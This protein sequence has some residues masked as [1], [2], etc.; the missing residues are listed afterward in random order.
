MLTLALGIAANTAIFSAVDA[1]LLHPLPFPHAEQLVD[2][3]KT[4]PMF[5]L[6]QSPASALDFLDYR[7]QSRAFTQIAA[8]ERAQFNLTG[9]REAVRVPG[10]RVS[11]SLFP[12]LDVGP[13]LGRAFTPEEE[14]WGSHRVAILGEPLWRARFGT[15][16]QILG[17]QVQLDGE[18]YTVIG[19]ARP[20]LTFLS[21]N[22][23]WVPLAFSPDQLAPN[24]RGHQHL[25]VVARLRPG[26][27]LAQ[28]SV[29]LQRVT[30]QL[31]K[32]LP[33]WYPGG[34]SINAGP[35]AA[36]VSGPI[37]TPLLVLLGAVA[38]VLL[39]GCVNVSNLLLA[40]ASSRQKEITIRTALGAGRLRIVRQLLLESAA[41][42]TVSGALGL[43]TSIWALDLFERL[44]PAGLLRGQHLAINLAVAAFTL[45]ISL[46]AALF[47]GLAPA[48]TASNTDLNDSLKET[49]R[50]ASGGTA[51]RR[52]REVLVASEVALSLALLISAGLL[53]R[54]F[55]QLQAA[56][57]GFQP[58]HL[59]TLQVN[60]PV[61]DY[62]QPAQITAFYD[63]LLTR[64]RLI[65]GVIAAGAINSLP[66]SGSNHGGDFKIIG[67]TWPASQAIPDVSLRSASAEY[68]QA[69]QIPVLKGRAFTAENGANAPKVAVVDEAFAKQFFA[70]EDPIGRQL[71]GPSKDPYTIIG[72]V[73]GVKH[74]S[75][76]S[77]PE[78]TIY[79]P[80]LQAP[81]RT[82]YIVIRTATD[83]LNLLPVVRE[84]VAALD[85]NLPVS[86]VS[87]MEQLMSDSLARTRF[88]TALLAVFAGLALLL[89]AIGVYGVIAYNVT[90]RAQEIGIRIALGARPR[91]AVLLVLRQG[92]TPVLT[93]ILAGFVISLGCG[94]ALGSLLYGVSAQDPLTFATLSI[95]FAGVAFAASYI[96]AR[97]AARLDPI[98][99]LRYE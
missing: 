36:R 4:M 93:G 72:V 31:T 17:K 23:L 91:D 28:A 10:M 14:Q 19:V 21:S 3:T 51:K 34:W 67:R 66:F 9:D 84:R 53:T 88:S 47:F 64:M 60:L 33:D 54:S 30:A 82:M 90:Q 62:R 56:S 2:I 61:I 68:F 86:R 98:V 81:E 5:E 97:K 32:Q 29:D 13:L 22:E 6:F 1:V 57:P 85:R 40:R 35:L 92:V 69:M 74:K 42:A 46:M 7:A 12:L 8:I 50:S 77:P 94:R 78:A 59:T 49:S 45:V 76:S 95:F 83:P 73:G 15:D 99:A 55:A 80:A 26:L 38:L 87:A 16:R 27:N 48:I 65:P 75:L 11:A 89:A 20:M 24:Q 71:N 63:Q 41:L 58:E 25:D 43:L 39:I 96:P 52:L 18:S 70:Q 44:G 79:Y 37:R